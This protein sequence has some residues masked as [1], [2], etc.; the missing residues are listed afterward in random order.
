MI[1]T[2]AQTIAIKVGSFSEYLASSFRYS[3]TIHLGPRPSTATILATFK[4]HSVLPVMNAFLNCEH[5]L[6]PTLL[7]QNQRS[8]SD[9][10]MNC[11]EKVGKTVG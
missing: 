2:S 11:N 1:K 4:R 9:R 5:D 3:V 7:S 8:V 6:E 10:S